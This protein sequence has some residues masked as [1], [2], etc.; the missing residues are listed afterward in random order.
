L[1]SEHKENQ[2]ELKYQTDCPQRVLSLGKENLVGTDSEFALMLSSLALLQTW[3]T[4][5]FI[6]RNPVR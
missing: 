1:L 6:K 2:R 4:F 5:L 3:K